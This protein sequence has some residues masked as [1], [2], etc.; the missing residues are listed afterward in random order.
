MADTLDAW[1][2]RE[3]LPHET[4]LLR[5]L[6]RVWPHRAEIH[7][8]R[9]ET[10]VR[11]YEAAARSRP[12]APRSF[13]FTTARHLMVDRQ[14]RSRVISIDLV[15]DPDSLN[16]L[17]DEVSPERRVGA[18][19]DL[20]RIVR[21]LNRLPPRCREVIWLKRV[22][23]LSNREIAEHLRISVRTV[24]NQ[25]FRAMR[26]LAEYLFDDVEREADALANR[27]A[28]PKEGEHG[29]P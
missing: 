14:R 4:A 9:Q 16:V 29:R 7:D 19:D 18:W 1:F 24:E 15:S 23:E 28:V 12:L 26:S 8:L 13:V 2:K 11:V 10:Y 5:Y 6:R 25:V 21:V 27:E 20:R 3:V 22:D 17:V